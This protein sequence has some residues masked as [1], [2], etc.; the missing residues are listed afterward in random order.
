M[1][2]DPWTPEQNHV[3][4]MHNYGKSPYNLSPYFGLIN[5][6]KIT[7]KIE[8][9]VLQKEE[10]IITQIKNKIGCTSDPKSCISILGIKVGDPGWL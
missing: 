1:E 6:K 7:D 2:F 4:N 8:P 3:L 10:I 5:G 9:V